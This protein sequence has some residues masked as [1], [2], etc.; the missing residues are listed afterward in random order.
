MDEEV[1]KLLTTS[2][3]AR[4][5]VVLDGAQHPVVAATHTVSNFF[6]KAGVPRSNGIY[7]YLQGYAL[8]ELAN[9]VCL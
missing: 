9:G 2:G 7:M 6:M 5:A 3:K 4:Q 8:E 1:R